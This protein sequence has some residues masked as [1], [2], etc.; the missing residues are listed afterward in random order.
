MDKEYA[1]FEINRE[2]LRNVFSIIS[3]GEKKMHL[4]D[5]QRF[6]QNSK[7]VPVRVT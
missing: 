4:N 2:K 6:C 1:L 7:L 3:K 5:F